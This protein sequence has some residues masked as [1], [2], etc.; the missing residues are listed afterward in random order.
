MTVIK[1]MD[2]AK[3]AKSAQKQL[4]TNNYFHILRILAIN[5]SR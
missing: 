3:M 5:K 4:S 1:V 2:E